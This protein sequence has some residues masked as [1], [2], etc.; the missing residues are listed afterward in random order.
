MRKKPPVKYT[1]AV[2]IE[3]LILIKVFEF[4]AIQCGNYFNWATGVSIKMSELS[5]NHIIANNKKK[6][7][8]VHGGAHGGESCF[9]A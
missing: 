1:L 4:S 6:N 2:I 3:Y 8:P 5:N 9:H 7:I